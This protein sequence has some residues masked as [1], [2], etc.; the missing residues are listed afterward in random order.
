MYVGG[1]KRMLAVYRK[2]VFCN[3]LFHFTARAGDHNFVIVEIRIDQQDI[4]TY[5]HVCL[6]SC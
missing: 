4:P 3:R 5:F 1:G 2:R 6:C